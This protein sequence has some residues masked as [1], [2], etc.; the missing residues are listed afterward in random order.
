MYKAFLVL[1]FE[2]MVLF[3]EVFYSRYQLKKLLIFRYESG[4]CAISVYKNYVP[5]YCKNEKRNRHLR[6]LSDSE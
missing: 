6:R 3:I 4:L 2:T 5:T 1:T